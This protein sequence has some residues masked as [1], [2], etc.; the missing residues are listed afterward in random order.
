MDV[1]DGARVLYAHHIHEP[2]NKEYQDET[3]VFTEQTE[4]Q[5]SAKEAAQLV[6]HSFRFSNGNPG[7]QFTVLY[8]I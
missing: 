3:L 5:L 8:L 1:V 4:R 6:W 2:V 7:L